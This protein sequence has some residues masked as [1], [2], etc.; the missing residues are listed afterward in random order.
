[1]ECWAALHS[2]HNVAARPGGSSVAIRGLN[3]TTTG[4]PS[5]TGSEIITMVLGVELRRGDFCP[6]AVW[7]RLDSWRVK[8]KRD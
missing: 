8:G 5:V 7:R 6:T 1:M 3:I 2:E 4:A